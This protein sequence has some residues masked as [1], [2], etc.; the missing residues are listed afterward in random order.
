MPPPSQAH[1]RPTP[2]QPPFYE[3]KIVQ[4]SHED[5]INDICTLTFTFT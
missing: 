5:T 3:E 4:P 1:P 2:G